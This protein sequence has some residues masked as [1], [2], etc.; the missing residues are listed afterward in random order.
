MR[1]AYFFVG[2]LAGSDFRIDFELPNCDLPV[3]C[4]TSDKFS[5]LKVSYFV[6]LFASSYLYIEDA[7]MGRLTSRLFLSPVYQTRAE[8]M[9]YEYVGKGLS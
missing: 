4:A 8:Y 2:L 5:L 7:S 3:R 6:S 9:L 1:L